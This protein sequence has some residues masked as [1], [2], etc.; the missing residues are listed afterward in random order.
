MGDV[1]RFLNVAM[2]TMSSSIDRLVKKAFVERRRPEDNRR[3]VA[4][5]TTD[6]GRGVVEDHIAGYRSTCLIMLRALDPVERKELI[7][8]TEKIAD[9]ET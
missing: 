2:T 3:S 5:S 8:L 1:A 4:L 9:N 6:A 7:R